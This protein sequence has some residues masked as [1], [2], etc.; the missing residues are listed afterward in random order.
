MSLLASHAMPLAQLIPPFSWEKVIVAPWRDTGPFM[1]WIV[2]MGFLVA[3]SCG[4]VGVFLLLRRLAMAGDAVS[5]SILPGLVAASVI[6]GTRTG[7]AMALGAVAAGLLTAWLIEFLHS[8]T[9]LKTDS[10]I[11]IT[12]T[13]LFALGVMGVSLFQSH[14]HLDAECVLFGELSYVPFHASILGLP[15]PIA[16]MLAVLLALLLV[17]WLG[18]QRLAVASFDPGLAHT[19]GCS[20]RRW[21]YALMAALS[22]VAVAS[23]QATGAILVVGM[24]V[25]PGASARL[26]VHRLPS[27]LLLS[28]LHAALSAIMGL[29]LAVWLDCQ[30]AASMVVAGSLLF[31]AAWG[32][33]KLSLRT[34]IAV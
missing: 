33:S 4:L 15:T 10:A 21:H 30:V 27:V 2:L 3:V 7:G 6:T 31:V 29:H 8:Q 11:G 16:S 17:G 5:H 34:G 18:F 32:F 22:L 19:L 9:R 26:L 14:G 13:T 12:F 20:P 28:V 23:F 1:G 24:L 25:L